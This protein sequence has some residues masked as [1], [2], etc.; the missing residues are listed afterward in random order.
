MSQPGNGFCG[1]K[2]LWVVGQQLC[3]DRRDPGRHMQGKSPACLRVP[4]LFLVLH[5]S[6]EI[7]PARKE[8]GL[9]SWLGAHQNVPSGM[10]VPWALPAH[11]IGD[12]A[13]RSNSRGLSEHLGQRRFGY[14]PFNFHPVS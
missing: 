6:A 11:S 4:V 10:N 5:L 1:G 2:G 8:K 7:P 13:L 3:R 12:G 9:R 14:K